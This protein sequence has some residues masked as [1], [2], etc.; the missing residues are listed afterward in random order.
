MICFCFAQSFT[1][2]FPPYHHMTR[3]NRSCVFCVPLDRYIGRH[4]DR[5][6]TDVSLDI[7]TDARPICRGII[8]V[9]W[10][11]EVEFKI[12]STNNDSCTI[13]PT[14]VGSVF[15]SGQPSSNHVNSDQFLFLGNRARVRSL[16]RIILVFWATE[17]EFTISSTN[18][19]SYTISPTF[20]IILVFWATEVEFTI[21]S[22]NSDSYTI[23]P[24]EVRVMRTCEQLSSI[25]RATNFASS[26]HH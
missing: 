6:A 23:S 16:E 10:A 21:S 12:S 14:E 25:L 17:V 19:D 3:L 18:N 8:L 2:P 9:F 20:G 11:T 15:V 1:R 13:S 26:F 7:S 4:V 24:T 5:H 22:T